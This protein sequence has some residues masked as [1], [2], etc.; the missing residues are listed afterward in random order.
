MDSRATTSVRLAS[1]RSLLSRPALTSDTALLVYLALVNFAVHLVGANNYGY[2]RDEL[3][4]LADGR[5]L[6]FGYV[7]Q[8]PLIGWLAALMDLLT[9]DNLVALHVVSA[10]AAACLTVVV[11]LIARELGGGRWAQLLAALASVVAI[12]FMATGSLFSMDVLDELWWALGAYVLVRLIRRQEPRLWLVFGLIAGVGLLTKL[13]M[14][15]FGFGVVAGFLLTPLRAQFRTRWP[16]L[17]G[18]IAFVFLL[19]Y[20]L[21][22]AVNGW[23]TPEFWRHYGGLSGGGPLGFFGNQILIINPFNLPLVIAGL[24]FYFRR[25]EG[26]PFRAL[27][28]AYVV[29]YVLFTLINA[30][31]YFLAPAYPILFAGGALVFERALARASVF[32]SASARAGGQRWLVPS[33]VT[34]LALS[35]LF[36]APF[37]MPLLPPASFVSNYGFL[38]GTGNNGAGQKTAGSFPQ[39]LG[40]RFG[41]ETMSATVAKVY[42]GLPAEQRA[43][44]CVFTVNYGEASALNFFAARYHL[45]PAISGHNN[46]YLWGPGSCTG[47][48]IITVG[49]SQG[50]AAMSFDS[51]VQAATITCDY[52]MDEENDLPVYV[53]TQPKAGLSQLWARV[54][55]YN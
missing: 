53:C 18:A 52:C 33:Y 21:W 41:W 25:P 11:G 37:A 36:F 3:Y 50:E 6:A 19:P 29:L 46:Y 42:A 35:G 27:G 32:A 10:L 9:H 48:V 34:A 31:A 17:G 8:P 12:V 45:P 24:L 4:Y 28:W 16:W 7:D 5:H 51:V 55:H 43:R 20:I 1:A 49:L 39:Y 54:K 44:A 38:T 14:L 40:D 30:K 47:D 2:F 13:T 22:N 23:P 26:K 15:F